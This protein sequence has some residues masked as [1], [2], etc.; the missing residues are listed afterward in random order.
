[1]SNN[2]T[3]YTLIG[4]FVIGLG[5]ALIAGVLWLGAGGPG[6]AFQLYLVYTGESVSGLSRDGAVKY[7]GVDVG[8]IREIGLAPDNPELVRLLLEVD[9]GTPIKQDTV[10]TLESQGLTGLG[11]V[12]LLGGS[13]SAAPLAAKPGQRYPVIPSRPSV[14]GSLDR[15][16]GELADNLIESSKRLKALLSDDNQQLLVSTLNNLN[17]VTGVM[18]GRADTV[19][20]ALDD[21][22][23]ALHNARGASEGLPDLVGQLQRSAASLERMA[24]EIAAAGT[25]LRTTVAARGEELSRFTGSALPD[26]AVM[27]Q[28]L[29]RA[30]ENFRRLSESLQR[31]PSI[32]LRGAPAPPPGPG[33]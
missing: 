9:Q 13:R 7:R 33:E 1:M 21:L 25:Q 6:Q 23:A 32:L 26:A 8:R 20:T 22:A 17:Q 14:W 16:L 29:R 10:A 19:G 24:T 15:R 3:Q 2:S 27:T 11:Y 28:E 18:A 12:N 31:D 4:L 30:A 5:T